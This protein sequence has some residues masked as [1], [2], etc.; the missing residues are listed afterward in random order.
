[1][2]DIPEFL[3]EVLKKRNIKSKREIKR[4]LF[5]TLND[6]SE[7]TIIKTVE[8]AT[9]E[10][11]KSIREKQKIFIY[12]DGDIDGIGGVFYLIQFLKGKNVEYDFYLS[13]RFDD[14]EIEEGLVDYFLKEGYKLIILVDIGI[15]S[16][17]FLKKCADNNLKVIVIDHHQTEFENLPENHIYIHPVLS[18][19]EIEFSATALSFK[20]F[21]NL[22][23]NYSSLS[24]N[25]Y[26]CIAG[27]ATLSENLRLVDDNRIFVKEMTKNLWNS[28]IKGLNLLF[29][30]YLSDENFK[31]DDIKIKINPKLNA[32]GRFGKPLVS[33]NLLFED[34]EKEIESLLKEID[35]LDRKRYKITKKLIKGIEKKEGFENRFLIFEDLPESMCGIIGSKLVEK[36][37]RPF[38]VMSKKK[39]IIKGSGR[40][41]DNFNIYESLK[42]IKNKFLS[43]GGHKNAVGFAFRIEN[44]EEIEK[45]WISIKID[46]FLKNE[47]YFDTEFDIENIKPEIFKYLELLEPYGKGN[48]PPIFLSRNV[49]IKE[50]KRINESKYWIKKG[51]KIFECKIL[52]GLK[53][54]KGIKDIFYTPKIEKID[55]YYRIY[56]EI[57][58]IK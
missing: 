30:R 16:Y 9:D 3:I 15:S 11:L 32:P 34:N 33:L 45:Y 55:G 7:P 8:F 35:Q 31:V 40:A 43:F 13:S 47:I 2:N 6:L 37:G 5:P 51:N 42:K 12:G 56:L 21:Q 48:N 38:L 57:K 14:Y 54:E 39:N 10:V 17:K 27:L 1:M 23:S 46:N 28:K 18:G 20:L 41:P 44:K 50:I 25:D 36:F 26:I 49:F 22:I 29:S 19:K 52:N 24:L 4:F 53:I 58:S